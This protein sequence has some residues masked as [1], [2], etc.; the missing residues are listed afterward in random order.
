MSK[1]R[2]RKKKTDNLSIIILKACKLKNSTK[3]VEFMINK[4]A[5]K[6]DK[7]FMGQS[8]LHIAAS[9]DNVSILICIYIWKYFRPLF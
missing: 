5:S 6:Y 1:K 9:M 3:L 7:N 4:G 8:V 2:K